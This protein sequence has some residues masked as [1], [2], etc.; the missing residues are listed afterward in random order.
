MT[1]A[2]KSQNIKEIYLNLY[3]DS[4][5]KGVHNYI[6]VDGKLSDGSYAPLD[7]KQIKFTSSFGKWEG[8]NLIIDSSYKQDS[9]IVTVTAIGN[10]SLTK[11]QVIYLKKINN[12]DG[13][14]TEKELLESWNT[15]KKKSK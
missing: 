4:L 13:M 10:T 14:K 9:V 15:K 1:M 8:N 5:K 12:T 3:T 7:S 11:T 6:N 2:G